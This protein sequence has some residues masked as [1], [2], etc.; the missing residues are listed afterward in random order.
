ML[1]SCICSK[2]I[3][4]LAYA[5]GG[6]KNLLDIYRPNNK[7]KLH[8]VIVF[9]H[10]GSWD[11][12]KKDTYW[13]LGRNFARKG[14]VFVAINYPLAPDA[15]YQEM[16]YDCANA[17][18]WVKENIKQYGGN[19]DKIFLMG[20]SAGGHLAALINQDP[21]YF[22]KAGIKNPIK[23]VVLD[24]PFGLDIDQYLKTQINTGDKY[25]P[26]FLKV[27]STDEKAWKDASP[28]Y[29]IDGIHNPYMMFVG[30][31]TFPAIKQQT[32]IFEEKM[33]AANKQ[34]S[35]EVIKGKKHIGM[36]TQMIFGCNKLYD[37]INKFTRGEK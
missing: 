36:I 13:F 22:A 30:E 12:G 17:V 27:F 35:L 25:V 37:R 26:G 33:K 4:D 20:H 24:D 21:K 1:S 14:K 9:I 15:Q 32:P 34:V 16:G 29:K 7:D 19:P 23:G 3:K 10:G 8:D 31:K 2:K 5:D 18:K 28:M 11:T 6:G